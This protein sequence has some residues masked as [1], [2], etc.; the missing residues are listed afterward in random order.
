M[1]KRIIITV[2][3]PVL[4]VCMLAADEASGQS[5]FSLNYLGE[6]VFGGDSRYRALAYSALAVPDTNSA[7]TLNPASRADL[8]AV[9]FS[10]IEVL[11]MGRARTEDEMADLNRYSLPQIMVAVPLRKGLVFSSGIVTGFM[12]RGDA[13]YPRS[14]EGIPLYTEVYEHRSSLFTVP[15]TLSWKVRDWISVAASY[16]LERGSTR[17]NITIDFYQSSYTD[18]E[19]SRT[20]SYSGDSWSG[21]FLV[22]IHPRFYIGGLWDHEVRYE[23]EETISYTRSEFDSA[24]VWKMALPTALGI[25]FSAGLSERWWLSSQYWRREAPE[26]VGFPQ[27]SGCVGEETLIAA[28]LERRPAVVGGFFGKIPLRFGFYQNKWHLEIPSGEAII[29]RFF[30]F[31]TSLAFPSGEGCIDLSLEFGQVGSIDGNGADERMV[32]IGFGLSV[33]EPWSGRKEGARY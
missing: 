22:R 27:F 3:A 17:N 20:R 15:L 2:C 13:E 25:G 12:G 23:V 21:A 9:T 31:G 14:A 24:A 5:I 29:S 32:R 18:S 7:L 1:R 30:T 28:G 4:F 26:A 19:F 11:E 8:S 33:S 6:H 10:I 16:E